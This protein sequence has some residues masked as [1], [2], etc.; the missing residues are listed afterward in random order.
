MDKKSAIDFLLFNEYYKY[1]KNI[2]EVLQMSD[3][4]KLA[5]DNGLAVLT[6]AFFMYRDL[7][8][9]TTLQTTLTTLVDTVNSLKE[10]AKKEDE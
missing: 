3:L 6:V 8:F 10:I 7:K 9:M 1:N 2:T 4:I 5:V